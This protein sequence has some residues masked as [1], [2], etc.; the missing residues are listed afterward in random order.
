MLEGLF[1]KTRV[2]RKVA[3]VHWYQLSLRD[4][5]LGE[6][7]RTAVLLCQAEAATAG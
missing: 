4:R 7:E 6:A 5:I 2:V 1:D 3:S